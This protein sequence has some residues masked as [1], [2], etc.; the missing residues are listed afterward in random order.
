MKKS[1]HWFFYSYALVDQDIPL[2]QMITPI[3]PDQCAMKVQQGKSEHGAVVTHPLHPRC[4]LVCCVRRFMRA[5][6]RPWCPAP[7]VTD[8]CI[9]PRVQNSTSCHKGR[10]SAMVPKGT[11]S[12]CC[13][14]AFH[15]NWDNGI[16]P[17]SCCMSLCQWVTKTDHSNEL[18]ANK[19]AYIKPNAI[20]RHTVEQVYI[21]KQ[22]FTPKLCLEYLSFKY[23]H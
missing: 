13:F 12:S 18:T 19:Q 6:Q 5:S 17:K 15:N 23:F 4:T 2:C 1:F 7:A 10:N 21:G 20:K 11:P 3:V 16:H 8:R 22:K 9:H 14:C